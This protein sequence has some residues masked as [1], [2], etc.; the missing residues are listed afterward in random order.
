MCCTL[1]LVCECVK[2]IISADFKVFNIC[3]AGSLFP[4][5]KS[6]N[7]GSWCWWYLFH[8]S[9]ISMDV[10]AARENHYE[11]YTARETEP[12]K[13]ILGTPSSQWARHHPGRVQ[14]LFGQCS[15]SQDVTFGD[16][17]CRAESCT[18]WSL[19]SLLT[20]LILWV[21]CCGQE[22][23]P[24]L[25]SQEITKKKTSFCLNRLVSKYRVSENGPG[26]A[27]W[28]QK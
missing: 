8:H 21:W 18:R 6:N 22:E 5:L 3:S 19:W 25:P 9:L 14:G 2:S 1:S 7:I 12:G 17:L 10:T 23:L 20:Q 16:V 27:H 15:Q 13:F 11:H 4:K 24:G 28:C 26:S